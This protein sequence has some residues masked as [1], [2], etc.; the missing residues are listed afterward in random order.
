MKPNSS[1]PNNPRKPGQPIPGMRKL[2]NGGNGR[3]IGLGLLAKQGH[4]SNRPLEPEE[5]GAEVPNAHAGL[6]GNSM[7]PV[8]VKGN[9]PCSNTS[10]TASST[11]MSSGAAL[12]GGGARNSIANAPGNLDERANQVGNSARSGAYTG[13]RSRSSRLLLEGVIEEESTG[14]IETN[15]TKRSPLQRRKSMKS[16]IDQNRNTISSEDNNAAEESP[17]PRRRNSIVQT[18]ANSVRNSIIFS[19]KS[20]RGNS[21]G[22]I[23]VPRKES[24]NSNTPTNQRGLF[25]RN[26][27]YRYAESGQ[28]AIVFDWDDTLF[29]TSYLIDDL[30]LNHKKPLKD[31][32]LPRDLY[33]ELSESLKELEQSVAELLRLALTRGK[34]ILVTLARSPWVEDSCRAFFPHV[35]DVIKTLGIKAVYAQQGVQIDYDKRKMMC[36][37]EIE[38][39]YADLKG[40]AISR[41]VEAFY[42]QYEGQSW[43]NIISIGD[44]DFERLGTMMMTQDY[45]RRRGMIKDTD[46]AANFP[47][48]IASNEALALNTGTTDVN[49]HVY[50]VR[51]K[52][53]KMLDCPTIGELREEVQFLRRWLPKMVELDDGFDADLS[54]LDDPQLM[55]QIEQ[56]LSGSTKRADSKGKPKK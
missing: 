14:A 43:K 1:N 40:K 18:V 9:D 22:D 30:C 8:P 47:V 41:E 7:W 10:T 6:E 4:L 5:G 48:A 55:Q 27:Q 39:F 37:Q 49:G 11:P 52:T 50:K 15:D 36:D 56:V 21:H 24:K 17:G 12:G 19:S 16:I 46:S 42:S 3:N 34:V 23:P 26:S 33:Q 28:T 54:A 2:S 35:G 29:P 44:S 13:S 25:R 31:Q 45:M 20:P 32:R 38:T 53:F 51:T